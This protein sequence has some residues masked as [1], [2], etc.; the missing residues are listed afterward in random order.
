MKCK[1]VYLGFFLGLFT[2]CQPGSDEAVPPV[3]EYDCAARV[4]MFS[5]GDELFD[6]TIHPKAGLFEDYFDLDAANQEHLRYQ[7]KLRAQ[8]ID[9]IDL[10]TVLINVDREQLRELAA[11]YLVFDASH[12]TLDSAQVE[13]YRQ[14]MLN[15]MSKKDLI[16]II[17]L[18]PTVELH[19]T[20]INTGLEARYIHAPLMNMYFMRDQSINTPCGAILGRMNSSQRALE[21]DIVEACYNQ[22][23]IKPVY[24]VNG[25]DSYLEGGDYL[26]FGT[27]AFIGQGLRT[28]QAALDE[29]ME[30]DVLGHD[31]IVVVRDHWKNQSQ[32][33]LDTYFNIIDFDLV[34]MCYNRYDAVSMDDENYLTIDMYARADKN[35]PYQLVSQFH[36]MGFSDFL[37]SRHISIIRI[38]ESDVAH[39][40]NNYLTVAH[41]HIYAVEGQSQE[42]QQMLSAYSVRV[43]WVPLDNLIKGYGA[44]HCMTQVISRYRD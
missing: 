36:N 19:Q 31:T 16:R 24:R 17:F 27:L 6:G 28:S 38:G 32:M 43:D 33:H 4:L 30:H 21:V 34:T 9:V 10:Q 40:G 41:R 1:I 14:E 18:Q 29:L 2:A 44:A 15:C 37:H 35:S 20:A 13:D 39:Y 8:G 22:L 7:R 23:G 11:R 3:A 25:P 5:P 12:T 26:P 42:Y